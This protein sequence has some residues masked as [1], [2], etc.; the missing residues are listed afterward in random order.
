MTEIENYE[1]IKAEWD[2]VN[3]AY[4]FFRLLF[5][6]TATFES[7][8]E[9]IRMTEA[10]RDELTHSGF[11]DFGM[12]QRLYRR[13]ERTWEALQYMISNPDSIQM[14]KKLTKGRRFTLNEKATKALKAF[15]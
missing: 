15:A 11:V 14:Q 4:F 9:S 2:A 5:L 1:P 7:V 3:E 12:A 8:E 6:G 13:R 10:E